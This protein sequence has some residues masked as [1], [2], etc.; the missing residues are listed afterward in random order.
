MA[1]HRVD[2]DKVFALSKQ[3][4][5]LPTE[6][7]RKAPHPSGWA[8]HR[9]CSWPGL[10]KVSGALSA[11][12]DDEWVKKLREVQDYKARPPAV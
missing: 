1:S 9:G 6:E 10:E 12:D 8:V 11:M 7:K 3:F 2:L 5:D 4:Y